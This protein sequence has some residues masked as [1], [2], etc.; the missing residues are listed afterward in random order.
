M[1]LLR[2]ILKS[3]LMKGKSMIHLACVSFFFCVSDWIIKLI[4]FL[5]TVKFHWWIQLQGLK[6]G[7]DRAL[8][9]NQLLT[10]ELFKK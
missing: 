1:H 8:Y 5:F 6:Q 3:L 4:L 9:E 7:G 2:L 10:S